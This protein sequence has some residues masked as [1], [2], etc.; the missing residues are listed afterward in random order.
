MNDV[1][2]SHFEL[3]VHANAGTEIMRLMAHQFAN[4]SVVFIQYEPL[5]YRYRVYCVEGFLCL[6]Y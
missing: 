3:F 1:G 2:F 6:Y 4:I 5:G